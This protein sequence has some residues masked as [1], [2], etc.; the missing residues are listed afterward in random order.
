MDRRTF[1]KMI[2]GLLTAA[3]LPAPLQ[4]RTP[5]GSQAEFLT[6]LKEKPWLLGY[7]GTPEIE[8]EASLQIVS[9]AVPRDL[10]G[11][12]FSQWTC[13]IQHWSR[14]LHALV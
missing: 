7:L 4:A 1:T 2:A 8:L 13:K 14:S 5:L 6:A 11:Q 10:E 9:G 12:F 3:S